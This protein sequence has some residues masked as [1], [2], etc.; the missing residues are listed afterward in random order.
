MVIEGELL[1]RRT[2][3]GVPVC[4]GSPAAC[5]AAIDDNVAQGSVRLCFVNSFT[6][7][8]LARSATYRA[9]VRGFLLLNDGIGIDIV[10]LIKHG[11][12]FGFN[13]NGTD[14]T[15][16]YLRATR[17]KHRVYLLGARP[18]IAEKAAAALRKIAPAHDY[19]GTH[20]GYFS[21]A[22]NK[23]LIADIKAR[24]ASLVLVALGNPRQE[25]WIADNFE[26]TGARLAIGVGALFDFLAEAVPRAPL[27]VRRMKL[28]WLYRLLL[29]PGRLWKRY[30]LFTPLLIAQ[31]LAE[32]AGVL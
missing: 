32:R 12:R 25:T 26:K 22:R 13:L 4:S 31:A 2:I 6:A 5:A 21:E 1:S 19:V 30:M 27:W 15:P 8:L 10:S 11:R 24:H 17:H 20:D 7:Y 16:F 14:F 9:R 3:S 28:E 23:D 29:E 18:G